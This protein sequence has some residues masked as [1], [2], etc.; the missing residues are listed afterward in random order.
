MDFLS[1]V[2]GYF[3]GL[4]MVRLCKWLEKEFEK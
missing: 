3:V 2:L 4:L 1:F